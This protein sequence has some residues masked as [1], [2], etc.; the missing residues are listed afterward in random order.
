MKTSSGVLDDLSPAELLEFIGR[1]SDGSDVTKEEIAEFLRQGHD[2][3]TEARFMGWLTRARRRAK[4]AFV[5]REPDAEVVVRPAPRGRVTGW[6]MVCLGCGLVAP[7]LAGSKRLGELAAVGH[8][9]TDHRSVGTVR[10]L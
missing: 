1:E 10:V 2:R 9:R 6:S 8:L 7:Q 4:E 3:K 5:G